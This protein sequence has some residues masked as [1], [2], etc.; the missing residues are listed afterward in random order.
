MDM[1]K[2]LCIAAVFAWLVLCAS[3]GVFA[4]TLHL[5]DGSQVHGKVTLK[6]EK[7]VTIVLDTGKS[8]AYLTNEIERLELDGQEPGQDTASTGNMERAQPTSVQQSTYQS[9]RPAFSIAIPERLS[10]WEFRTRNGEQSPLAFFKT[11]TDSLPFISTS[12]AFRSSMPPEIEVLWADS[13]KLFESKLGYDR[14]YEQQVIPDVVFTSDRS[15][16]LAG[17]P[18]FDRVYASQQTGVT[19]HSI[20]VLF[21]DAIVTFGLNA[22]TTFFERDDADFVAIMDTLRPQ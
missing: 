11:S 16:S 19:Y 3:T 7:V 4:D 13:E 14:L 6:S 2:G 10:D 12:I 5:K 8:V 17:L 22:S 20:S 18:A 21:N 1:T 15:I 9:P